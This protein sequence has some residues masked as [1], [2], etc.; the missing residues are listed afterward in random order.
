MFKFTYPNNQEL[1][2]T[3]IQL[4]KDYRI[5]NNDIAKAANVSATTVS[6]WLNF[7][8]EN[9]RKEHKNK[10]EEFIAQTWQPGLICI[11][12]FDEYPHDLFFNVGSVYDP[13][14]TWITHYDANCEKILLDC[15]KAAKDGR[16][17][18]YLVKYYRDMDEA[19]KLGR[20]EEQ[21]YTVGAMT[22]GRDDVRIHFVGK[23]GA[24]VIKNSLVFTYPENEA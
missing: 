5:S 21:L 9:L 20:E 15:E 11:T 12:A 16:A 19:N 7:K 8:T 2:G 4:K 18:K 17:K 13:F 23:N 3:L 24:L 22:G 14:Y 10:L 1:I 6:K